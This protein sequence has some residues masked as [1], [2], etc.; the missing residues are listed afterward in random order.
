MLCVGATARTALEE[1]CVLTSLA[2][3]AELLLGFMFPGGAR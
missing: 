1:G 3:V 2:S